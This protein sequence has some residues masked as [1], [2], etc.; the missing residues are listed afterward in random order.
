MQD[1]FD[2]GARELGFYTTGEPFI[3]KNI[4][5]DYKKSKDIGFEYTYI[6]TN[7]ALAIPIK[8]RKSNWRRYR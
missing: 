2:C 8:G 1:S 4:E 5:K 7:G 6:S 3:Y